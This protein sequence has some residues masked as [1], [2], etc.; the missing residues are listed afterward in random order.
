MFV[1]KKKARRKR[2]F[3]EGL[4]AG[5]SVSKFVPPPEKYVPEPKIDL[6][7]KDYPVPRSK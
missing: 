4:F 7:A 5:D 6:N 2:K 1:T 3:S